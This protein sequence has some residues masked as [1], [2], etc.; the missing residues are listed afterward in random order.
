MA[1][2]SYL[3]LPQFYLSGSFE[4][5]CR[6]KLR[7]SV[8][9]TSRLIENDQENYGISRSRL[10]FVSL[11]TCYASSYQITLS[12]CFI[13]RALSSTVSS[14]KS[15]QTD[16]GN[17]P[18]VAPAHYP[19]ME[20]NRVNCHVWVL[21]ESARSFSLA[22]QTLELARTGPEL[23]MAWIGVD[24]H[25]WHK[26]IAYQVAVYALLKAA[27]EV[28]LFLSHKRSNNPS[29]VHVIYN[30]NGKNVDFGV[31]TDVFFILCFSLTPKTIFLGECI[32][33][34]LNVR[35][36]KL[37]QWF[38]MVEVPR[39]AGLFIPLF[40]KWSMEYAGSGVAGII[41]AISCCAAVRK[42]GSGRVSCTLF[43]LSIEDALIELMN[44]SHDLVSVDK[45]HSLATEAG[46]E[47]D[48][49]LHFGKKVLPSKNIEEVE[50][51]IGLV[52]KKLSTAFRRESVISGK[53]IFSDKV[54]ENSLATLGLFAFL[55]RETRLFLLRM[56][57]KDLDEQ[58]KDFLSYLECGSLFIYPEFSSLSEYRLFMEVVTVEIGWLDFYSSFPSIFN[59]ERRRSKQR[60]IQA[61]KEIILNT[62]FTVCYD[63]FSGFAHFTS[64]TQ[65]P[66]DAN[67]LAFLLQR[68]CYLFVWRTTG[69]LMIDQER[70]ASDSSPSSQLKGRA[71]SSVILEANPKP[72]DLMKSG[73]HQHGSR[74]SNATDPV[75]LDPI[76]VAEMVY[77]AESEPLHKSLLRKST[78]TLISASAD[79]WMGSQLLFIDI[80]DTM[81]L[82]MKKLRGN[83]VT[84]RERRKIERTLADI[85]SLIPIIILMLLPVSAVGHAA[86][87]A[88]IQKYMPRLIP[89]PYSPERLDIVKQLERTKKM[90]IQ[91]QI[92]TD[93]A[94]SILF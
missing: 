43:S 31:R 13:S 51:W 53:Q 63:V 62:V 1:S 12:R 16:S 68:A 70:G 57:I 20:F 24:V 28:E 38:R 76:T 69:L 80:L 73:D 45:L 75:G 56:G 77:V 82:L 83:K 72:I 49:L 52:Q 86:M 2:F 66:L 9:Y 44:F 93:D 47:E 42:L 33:S 90:K 6:G 89:T 65:Q 74:L 30:A 23:S 15:D 60:A 18:P 84:K 78:Y 25:A 71:N 22:I 88:A 19:A 36:P 17:E 55:G 40:K 7:A 81:G 67:L 58:V 4:L 27:I 64:S 26:Q 87:L 48:F 29:A 41:L 54:Q 59:Q 5:E 34:Q 92:N 8:L 10:P 39:I 94:S 21:H 14:A 50:F 37:V 35:H 91:L 61:E 46:F 3:H 32:E 85:A 11:P 79:M